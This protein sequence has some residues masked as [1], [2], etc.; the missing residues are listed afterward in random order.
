MKDLR[1]SSYY[2]ITG[3]QLIEMLVV[4]A[5]IVD[6]DACKEVSRLVVINTDTYL[7]FAE[8]GSD[9]FAWHDAGIGRRKN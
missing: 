7:F 4:D 5:V 1:T 3:L 2:V 6:R 8:N 9:D